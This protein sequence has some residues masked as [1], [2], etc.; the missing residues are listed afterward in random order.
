MD[1]SRAPG[2]QANYTCYPHYMEGANRGVNDQTS[3]GNSVCLV[4][5]GNPYWSFVPGQPCSRKYHVVCYVWVFDR[6]R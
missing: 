5:E 1:M 4:G 6:E 2:S 3:N